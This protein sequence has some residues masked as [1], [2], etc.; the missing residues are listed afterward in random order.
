MKRERER[1]ESIAPLLLEQ[2]GREH[3]VRH[4]SE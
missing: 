2:S 1:V 4:I 3:F